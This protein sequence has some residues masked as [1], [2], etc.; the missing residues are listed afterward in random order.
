MKKF[1][2]LI[3]SRIGRDIY[4][5]KNMRCLKQMMKVNNAV[6]LNLVD[7]IKKSFPYRE[8]GKTIKS[9]VLGSPG[10]YATGGMQ[11]I[12]QQEASNTLSIQISD[13]PFIKGVWCDTNSKVIEVLFCT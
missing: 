6:R 2:M 12:A 11:A 1:S 7:L 5:V 4:I 10:V 8:G 3:G 9:S 13:H